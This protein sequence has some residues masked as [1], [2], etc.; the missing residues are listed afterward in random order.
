[1]R[2]QPKMLN[3]PL[4]IV[5]ATPAH[6]LLMKLEQHGA[7][8]TADRNLLGRMLAD[9]RTFE[10]R[11]DIIRMGENPEFVHL[12]IEGWACRY[13]IV[14]DGQ[15][16]ITAF[17]VPGDFCDAHITMLGRMDHSIGA[18]GRARVAFIAKDLMAEVAERPA[19]TRSLW[20]AS[21][22][23]EGI[24]RAW[25]VNMGRR[26]AYDRV[27]HLICELEARL[28]SVGIGSSDRFELPL[29]QE[30]MGDAL[31]LSPV[32]VNRVLRRLR[33]QNLMTISNKILTI[34]N[35]SELRRQ[36]GFGGQYLH[37][38]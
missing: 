13:S 15:R 20:W 38:N 32:H 33:E 18:L 5:E 27:A 24:L 29:T 35:L 6:P 26:D 37:L 30:D 36:S 14:D 28:K 19:L 17:L 22:V 9:I 2:R 7:L 23:D 3:L 25:L 11:R 16:Q 34:Q 8:P 21:L 31:G 4:A 1:M 10:G 12:M